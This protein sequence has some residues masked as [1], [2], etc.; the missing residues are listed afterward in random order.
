MVIE[1]GKFC[2]IT[3]ALQLVPTLIVFA[4]CMRVVLADDH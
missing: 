4:V 1:L 2:T 3:E